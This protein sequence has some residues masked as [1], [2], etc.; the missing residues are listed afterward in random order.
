MVNALRAVGGRVTAPLRRVARGGVGTAFLVAAVVGSGSRRPGS[1]PTTP[2]CSCSRTAPTGA[3]LV[4]LI[5]AFQPVSASF[6]P[7]VT[8]VDLASAARRVDAA[9]L[10]AAQSSGASAARSWPT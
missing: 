2:A 9:P 4:A 6:N 10:I 7:V 1:R 8:L 5:L 3:V